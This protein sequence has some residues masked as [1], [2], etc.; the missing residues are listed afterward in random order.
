MLETGLHVQLCFLRTSLPALINAI[1][2][3]KERH[4]RT[5]PTKRT[6]L[7]RIDFTETYDGYQMS[8]SGTR[9]RLAGAVD[10]HRVLWACARLRAARKLLR[11]TRGTCDVRKLEWAV[12]GDAGMFCP[13][14][15]GRKGTQVS[16]EI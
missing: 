8:E 10:R 15:S 14:N 3:L 6:T 11:D 9:P 13:H 1:L 4:T 7:Q 12:D 5:R 16:G 2:Q